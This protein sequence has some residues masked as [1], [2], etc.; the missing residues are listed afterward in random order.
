[1][2]FEEEL[3]LSRPP[4]D[5]GRF[6]QPLVP[7]TIAGQETRLVVDTG[8]TETLV[9]R[10]LLARARIAVVPVEPGRDHAGAD[11]LTWTTVDDIV[12]EIAGH[13]F[14]LGRVSVI[15]S[16]KAFAQ[17]GIGGIL[18]PQCL[19][20]EAVLDLDLRAGRISLS[21]G[22]MSPVARARDGLFPLAL[23]AQRIAEDD[24][25]ENLT[26]IEGSFEDSGSILLMLNTGAWEAELNAADYPEGRAR[27]RGLSGAAIT[28]HAQ[29][30][31]FSID[32][33]VLPESDVILRPQ[34]GGIG[35]QIGMQHLG[36]TR[37]ELH[38][39]SRAL[40]WWVPEA[41]RRV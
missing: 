2:L 11:V 17:I 19:D 34:V 7:A 39:A 41:W 5:N 9:T 24:D 3:L 29:R 30:G 28:G 21:R 16:P 36:L 32:G 22:R 18:A 15:E 10:D 31:R 40:R 25:L 23:T 35:G 1:M 26:L 37:L 12:L 20:A 13:G 27:G 4:A 38:R 8:A 14:D 6:R 33:A